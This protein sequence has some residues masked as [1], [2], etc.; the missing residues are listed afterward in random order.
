MKVDSGSL[1]VRVVTSR[2]GWKEGSQTERANRQAAQRRKEEKKS[3]ESERLKH[4]PG[5]VQAFK[6]LLSNSAADVNRE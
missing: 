1:F 2:C 5:S 3:L 4:E 6:G